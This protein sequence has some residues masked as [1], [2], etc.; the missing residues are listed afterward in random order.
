MEL[1]YMDWY[2]RSRYDQ[3]SVTFVCYVLSTAELNAPDGA[4]RSGGAMGSLDAAKSLSAD[5]QYMSVMAD[6]QFGKSK[7]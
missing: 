7:P 5:E 3:C 1:S 2:G 6:L 4:G